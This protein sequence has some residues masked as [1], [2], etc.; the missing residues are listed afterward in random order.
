MTAQI[1]EETLPEYGEYEFCI[2]C[3]APLKDSESLYGECDTCIWAELEDATTFI[4][5]DDEDYDAW[6]D[7]MLRKD[8][9][10]DEE[11]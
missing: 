8:W 5:N 6:V 3:N 1:P 4:E 10:D 11:A 7:R 9:T 2:A